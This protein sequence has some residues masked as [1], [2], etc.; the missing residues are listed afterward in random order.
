VLVPPLS[1]AARR[2]DWAE[3]LQFLIF[4]LVAPGLFVAGAPWRALGCARRARALADA[5]R[6][7]P[8]RLRAA[9]FVAV[10]LFC[11]LAWRTPPAVNELHV[12]GWSVA[13]EAVSLFVTGC[14]L[15]LECLPSSPL[16]PR[17]TKQ[18]CIVLAAV[19][20]WAIWVLAYLLAMS[21]SNWYRAYQHVA[22]HGLSLGADQQ[23]AAG[24]IWA[25]AA[26]CFVPL[27]FWYLF[28]WLR[29]EEDP[30]VALRRFVSEERRR[31]VPPRLFP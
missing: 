8:E 1:N 15:F 19:S 29:S 5:R 6:R 23:I 30:D 21:R 16:S 7:H 24:L 2:D 26:L 27:I 14:G 3:A 11:D 4:S 13:L 28:D 9:A 17:S 10:A 31:S 20:M 22:G 25:V 12:G 18:V